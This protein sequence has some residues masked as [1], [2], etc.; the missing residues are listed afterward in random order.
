MVKQIEEQKQAKDLK[1]S[2]N[3]LASSGQFEEAKVEELQKLNQSVEDS[4]EGRASP[5]DLRGS[6]PVQIIDEP[7][8]E[9]ARAPSPE[10]IEPV[11]TYEP[12]TVV[13]QEPE[14]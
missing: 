13:E 5:L 10:P 6:D 14:K 4:I 12:K 9:P 7:V 8:E 3:T 11:Q 2:L 1:E